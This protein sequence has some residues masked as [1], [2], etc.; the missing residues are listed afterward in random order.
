MTKKE[1]LKEIE[2]VKEIE[3]QNSMGCPESF[4]NEYFMV[5]KF[6]KETEIDLTK[7][8][9]AELENLL[10]LAKFASEVFY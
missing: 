8:S 3:G 1:I 7:L 2:E 5:R 6:S 4:Y 10:K 9:V